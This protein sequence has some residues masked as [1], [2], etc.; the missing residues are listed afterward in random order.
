MDLDRYAHLDSPLHNWDARWKFVSLVLLIF[1]C[2]AS[3]HWP[4]LTLAT[5]SALMLIA[6][7][8]IP[9]RFV[10]RSLRAPFLL[11]LLMAFLLLLT[12]GGE[13]LLD[14]RG[15]ALSLTGLRLAAVIAVKALTIFLL[16]VSLFGTAPVH[17]TL[18]AMAYFKIPATLITLLL[19]TYRYI[20]LYT[21]E[22]GRLFVAARLRGYSLQ[23]GLRHLG[24]NAGVLV[25]LLIRGYE[26]GERVQAA[27]CLRGFEGTFRSL[28]CFKT[29]PADIAKSAGILVLCAVCIFLETGRT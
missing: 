20:F 4:T 24:S 2:A 26:Q 10:L 15:P 21:E 16:F 12:G 9:V 14:W 23:K 1:V 11:L 25:T 27:M 6:L 3:V 29:T 13:P 19:F 17:H 18:K 28:T 22:L 5:A 8:R 7:S